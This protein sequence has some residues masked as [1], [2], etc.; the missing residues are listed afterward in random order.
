MFGFAECENIYLT[1]SELNQVD[2]FSDSI[3]H[4]NLNIWI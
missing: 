2:I 3:P 4:E 1:N